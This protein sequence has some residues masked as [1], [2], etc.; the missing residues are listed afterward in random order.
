MLRDLATRNQEMADAMP[1]YYRDFAI[2]DSMIN[3]SAIQLTNA[4]NDIQDLLDQFFVDTATWGLAIWERLCG[5]PDAGTHS[6]WDA[7]S[8][9][10]VS[11]DSIE[12]ES[13]NMLESQFVSNADERRSAIKSQLRGAGTVTKAMI[14]NVCAA[15]T[16]GT[17][18]VNE[19][20]AEFRVEIVFTDI[21]G[22]PSNMD[23]LQSI[24]SEIIPAH[25]VVDYVYRYLRWNELDSYN[26][27]WDTL[28]AKDYTWDEFST[29][30]Q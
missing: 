26:Y 29:A 24:L 1:S 7:I 22:V 6:V 25:L 14:Q 9:R 10:S 12:G 13:W 23:T 2:V 27:T 30:I 15:Y 8:G 20:S 18:E 17:V 21:A 3:A 19:Y 4:D 5:F 28:D 11:F 16:G